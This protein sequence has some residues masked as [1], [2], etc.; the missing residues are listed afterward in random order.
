MPSTEA[1]A[2]GVI[3]L[4]E[5]DLST[6]EAIASVLR[7]ERYDVAPALDAEEALVLLRYGLRPTLM[8]LDLGM[9]EMD[10]F[11]FRAA[12]EALGQQLA[13]IPF[14]IYS[15]HSESSILAAAATLRAKGAVRK[16]DIDTILELVAEAHN[17]PADSSV[18][19]RARKSS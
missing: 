16:P 2:R 9:P 3:L 15:A 10:A 6:L 8:I 14:L 4:V 5:D 17:E 11:G 18:G 12:L 7:C 19:P 1:T 13:A